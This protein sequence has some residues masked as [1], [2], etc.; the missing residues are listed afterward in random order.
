[1]CSPAPG[2]SKEKN[3][4]FN[5]PIPYKEMKAGSIVLIDEAVVR[6]S[7]ITANG[8][9][10]AHEIAGIFIRTLAFIRMAMSGSLKNGGISPFLSPVAKNRQS[11][12]LIS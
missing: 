4:F 11:N 6:G 3:T 7:R 1:M 8:P 10:A 2:S 5:S 9:A 12:R